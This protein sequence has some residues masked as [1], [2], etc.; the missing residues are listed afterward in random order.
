MKIFAVFVSLVMLMMPF[1][2][3]QQMG[4]STAAA[5]EPE[6]TEW[7]V[8][9]Q[10][11]TGTASVE[12]GDP[13]L[14][15]FVVMGAY[16]A[17]TA[18]TTYDDVKNGDYVSAAIGITPVGKIGKA[19]KLFKTTKDATN[20]ATKFGYKKVNDYPFNSHGQAVYKK[21]NKYISPD[22]DGHI[23]GVWKMFDGKGNRLGTYDENLN[24]IGD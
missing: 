10:D 17:Y 5:E 1:A 19:G 6:T 15:W 12:N 18:Y 20:A 13:E 2:T 8:V 16:W 11:E 14:V 4:N 9:W 3:A 24:R 23:G 22:A 21:G 7:D